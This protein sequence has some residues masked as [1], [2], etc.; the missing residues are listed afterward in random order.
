MLTTTTFY[1]QNT[2]AR[3]VKKDLL[4]V[5]TLKDAKDYIQN[6]QSLR[7]KIYVYNQ[8]KHTNA[9]SRELFKHQIG[10]V[11]VVNEKK[12]KAVYKIIDIVP[13]KHFRANYIFFSG[14]KMSPQAIHFLRD[15]IAIEVRKGKEFK[16]FAYKY[17]MDRNAKQGGDIGWFTEDYMSKEFMEALRKHPV[18]T[19][20]NLD[21]PEQHKYYLVQQTENPKNINL[22]TVL[23]VSL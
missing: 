14:K 1:A 6:H 12:S 4:S 20:Y 18:N 15:E 19:I 10:D 22:L 11:F 17:S 23:K 21:L 3:K 16:E 8:V 9:L 7:S 13:K 5:T 2:S